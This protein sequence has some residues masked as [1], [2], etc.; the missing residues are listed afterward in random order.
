MLNSTYLIVFDIT[1]LNMACMLGCRH[2][3]ALALLRRTAVTDVL[4][5]GFVCVYWHTLKTCCITKGLLS[6]TKHSWYIIKYS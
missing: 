1:I 5:L 6:I 2:T 3:L 4:N